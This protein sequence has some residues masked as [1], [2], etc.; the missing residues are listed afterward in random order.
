MILEISLFLA[1]LAVLYAYFMSH[2]NFWDATCVP[3]LKPKYPF[4]G[5][6]VDVLFS[7]KDVMAIQKDIYNAFPNQRFVGLF[8]FSKPNLFVRD[9]AVIE[10]ITIKDFAFASDRGITD[11]PRATPLSMHL[12]NTRDD[13]WRSLRN[14]LTPTFSAGKLKGMLGQLLDCADA[15][16]KHMNSFENGVPFEARDIIARFTTDV[17][18]SCAFGLNIDSINDPKCLFREFGKA[19]FT[20]SP[21]RK[22]VTALR[23]LAGPLSCYVK[24]PGEMTPDLVDFFIKAVKDT[25]EYRKKNGVVRPDFLHLMNELFEKDQELVRSGQLDPKD[26]HIFDEV[27]LVSNAFVFFTAGFETTATTISYVMYELALHDDIQDRLYQEILEV[28]KRYNGELT[29]E[30]FND[31]K[32]LDQVIAETQRLRPAI[33]VLVRK[34]TKEYHVPETNVV[35]P[36]GSFVTLPLVALYHDPV[37]FPQPMEFDP[38]RFSK[39]NEQYISKGTFLPFGI[40]PRMCIGTRFAKL[41]MKAAL[42]TMVLKFKFVTCDKTQIPMIY[43]KAHYVTT[44]PKEGIWL[45]IQPRGTAAA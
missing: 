5:N 44:A 19:M 25:L 13:H 2:Y 45:E 42:V 29:F 21:S 27:T 38:D 32:Y 24:V 4:F 41:T 10:Q 18:A 43:D 14:K 7:L 23:R 17:I 6:T 26:P 35:M 36:V 16:V 40:G 30:A 33:A 28:T 20:F 31:M 34:I 9:P 3:A 15:L 8:T 37:H 12:I 39:E 22:I 11:D 1:S